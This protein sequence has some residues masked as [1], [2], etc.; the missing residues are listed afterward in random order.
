[1]LAAAV[2]E[3]APSAPEAAD[4]HVVAG[5]DVLVRVH[6]FFGT[7][8][9]TL[10]WR[11]HVD[12]PALGAKATAMIVLVGTVLI[13][14]LGNLAGFRPPEFPSLSSLFSPSYHTEPSHACFSTCPEAIVNASGSLPTMH[15]SRPRD[16]GGSIQ[17]YGVFTRSL[18]GPLP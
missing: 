2:S 6:D 10:G 16:R 7:R 8:L 11:V 9:A 5:A 15:R 1:V 3:G 18:N 13:L 4:H 14:A 17:R 12:E